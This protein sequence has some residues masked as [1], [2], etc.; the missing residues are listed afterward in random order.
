MVFDAD[1][2]KAVDPIIQPAEDV[3]NF[4]NPFLDRNGNVDDCSEDDYETIEAENDGSPIRADNPLN[5][6]ARN[7]DDLQ[8]HGSDAMV[9]GNSVSQGNVVPDTVS[10][11]LNSFATDAVSTPGSPVFMSNEIPP[12]V[13]ADM[14]IVS[15][16]WCDDNEELEENDYFPYN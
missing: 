16:L 3:E 13:K 7:F 12:N 14:R 11:S 9:A 6:D 5:G 2:R 8:S 4:A 1:L 15:K 10:P